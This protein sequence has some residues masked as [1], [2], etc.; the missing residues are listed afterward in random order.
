MDVHSNDPR[1]P[2]P[3]DPQSLSPD[4]LQS[5]FSLNEQLLELLTSAAETRNPTSPLVATLYETFRRMDANTRGQ[6]SRAP[7]L[8]DAGF[9]VPDRWSM[10]IHQASCR[11]RGRPEH[12]LARRQAVALA[13]STFFIAWHLVHTFPHASKLLLGMCDPCISFFDRAT[14]SDVQRLSERRYEWIRPRWELQPEIWEDLITL[15]RHPP[16]LLPG[17]VALRAMALI[18]AEVRR[19]QR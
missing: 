18:A 10:E 2:N 16:K 5:L 7:L 1:Q 9:A 4:L 14:V 8:I 11:S 12:W 13:R 6:L 19:N 15:A 17:S 3:L